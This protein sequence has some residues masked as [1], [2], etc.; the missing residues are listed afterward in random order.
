MVRDP[1]CLME[2]DPRNAKAVAEYG[3]RTYYFCSEQ[4]QEEFLARPETF[5]D[6]AQAL[7][8]HT[9]GDSSSGAKKYQLGAE[10]NKA[11]AHFAW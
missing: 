10:A 4:C 9:D 1:V 3:G 8:W 6:K 11:F 5:L 7:D 2:L